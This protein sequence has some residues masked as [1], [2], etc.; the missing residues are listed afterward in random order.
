MDERAGTVHVTGLPA[1]LGFLPQERWLPLAFPGL[2]V[3]AAPCVAFRQ[4]PVLAH[5]IAGMFRF[6]VAFGIF[7]LFWNARKLIGNHYFIF[8]FLGIAYPYVGVID[9]MHALS[10]ELSA[11]FGNEIYFLKIS[12][13]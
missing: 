5:L 10:A 13:T 1:N 12:Q 9:Y 4:T 6:V 11:I 3:A 2:L 7:M 8:L